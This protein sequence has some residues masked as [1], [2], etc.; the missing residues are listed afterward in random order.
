[1]R[2][3][4][5]VSLAAMFLFALTWQPA[6]AQAPG[7]QALH[8][9]ADSLRLAL[10]SG[11]PE[12]FY[13]ALAPWMQ[14]RIDLST[15]EFVGTVK[16]FL[17]DL[18]A[19]KRAKSEREFLEELKD[20]DPNGVLGITSFDDL[21]KLSSAKFLA[22]EFGTP[23]MQ[24]SA[25]LKENREARWH[26]VERLVFTAKEEVEHNGEYVEA[27]VTRGLVRFAT[28]RGDSI[29]VHAVADGDAWQVVDLELKLGADLALKLSDQDMISAPATAT[30]DA[31]RSE[32]EQ[33][34]GA[35]RDWSRVEYA[36][37]G[38]APTKLTR[39][40]DFEGKY[41][42]VRETV[43]KKPDMER[44][45]IV[46]EPVE[47]EALGYGAL[48]FNYAEGGGDIEWYDSEKDLEEALKAFQTAK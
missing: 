6:Q 36:K 23:K 8:N 11:T 45:A 38:T 21:A 37:T 30:R 14:G 25:D 28:I 2:K 10:L 35:A 44:G 48:Y 31:R 17:K 16:D 13:N 40:G 1:M 43:Y 4:I 15:E 34:M 47:D 12:E 26:E 7:G 20:D 22:L 24:A 29:S 27:D 46:A 41:F 42:K 5:A 19:D 18:D 3:V 33:L 9:K 39:A 32:G